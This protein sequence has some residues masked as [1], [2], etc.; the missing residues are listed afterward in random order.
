LTAKKKRKKKKNKKK[1][2]KKSSTE[3]GFIIN[4]DFMNATSQRE[5]KPI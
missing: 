4:L 2:E 5:E 1:S 3:P